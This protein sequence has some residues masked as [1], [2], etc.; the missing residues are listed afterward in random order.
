MSRNPSETLKILFDITQDAIDDDLQRAETDIHS[1]SSEISS[2]FAMPLDVRTPKIDARL[3]HLLMVQASDFCSRE[4]IAP[5]LK[6][7]YAAFGAGNVVQDAEMVAADKD[8][9]AELASRMNAIRRREGLAVDE[10]WE[11]DEGPQ[12]YRELDDEVGRILESVTDTVFTFVMRR[13]HIDE[14]ADLFERNR[15]EFEIQREI[16][17]RVTSPLSDEAEDVQKS[18]DDNFRRKYGE[19]ALQRVLSRSKQLRRK[20]A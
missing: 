12:D 4:A 8:T 15:V 1:I 2:L 9:C 7:F 18:M 6:T 19:E 13:Y 5:E 10:F 17:S 14:Q 11:F 20:R 3:G 16:G